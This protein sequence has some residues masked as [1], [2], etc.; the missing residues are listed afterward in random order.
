MKD[1]YTLLEANENAS[2]DEIRA[3][4]RRLAKKYHPDTNPLDKAAEARFKEIGE[5]YA[6]LG[7]EEKRK[8]YDKERRGGPQSKT[9]AAGRA[10]PRRAASVDKEG[11]DALFR[12][13]FAGA[14]P[15]GASEKKSK[16][17][18]I[19]ANAAFEKFFGKR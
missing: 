11:I 16:A 7:N 17:G 10:T 3:S 2:A 8:A 14:A 1:F 4:Y 15:K 13:Y 19:D 6:V 12:E 18:P 5:A 9:P